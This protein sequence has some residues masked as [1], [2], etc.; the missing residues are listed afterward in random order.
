[1]QEKGILAIMLVVVSV[2][3]GWILWPFFGAILWGLLLSIIF[4]PV[5]EALLTLMPVGG[6]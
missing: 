5:Y 6:M 3:F 1:M 4:T 2:A